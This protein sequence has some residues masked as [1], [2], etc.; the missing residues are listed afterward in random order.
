MK[1]YS[2]IIPG[3]TLPETVKA[4]PLFPSDKGP[5]PLCLLIDISHSPNALELDNDFF[6]TIYLVATID[7]KKTVHELY[8]LHVEDRSRITGF[9]KERFGELSNFVLD[10]KWEKTVKEWFAHSSQELIATGFEE[11]NPSPLLLDINDGGSS[12]TEN[13]SIC[14]DDSLLSAKSFPPYNNSL[15]RILVSKSEDGEQSF[16][17]GLTETSN[18]SLLPPETLVSDSD[19]YSIFNIQ[20]GRYLLKKHHCR[21]YLEHSKNLSTS[22]EEDDSFDSAS[23]ALGSGRLFQTENCRES[24]ILEILHLKLCIFAGAVGQTRREIEKTKEPFFNITDKS[25]SVDVSNH[26]FLPSMWTSDVHLVKPGVAMNY[27]L[28]GSDEVLYLNPNK[29]EISQYWPQSAGGSMQGVGTVLFQEVLS[30]NNNELQLAGTLDSGSAIDCEIQDYVWL[31]LEQTDR[32]QDLFLQIQKEEMDGTKV[33]FRTI[34]QQLSQE[35]KQ[36]ILNSMGIPV[37]NTFWEVLPVQSSA[38]DLYSL[39][40]LGVKTFLESESRNCSRLIDQINEIAKELNGSEISDKKKMAEL[41]QSNSEWNHLF[42][43]GAICVPEMGNEEARQLLP[44]KVWND[45]LYLIIKMFHGH[46]VSFCKHLGDVPPYNLSAP[47]IIAEDKLNE[48]VN[49]LKAILFGNWNM[50]LEVAEVIQ[51][52][53]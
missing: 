46:P 35:N 25:F 42:S 21:E 14:Q 2:Q 29:S 30:D 34:S 9:F 44:E 22:W 51:S 45:I 19:K 24:S 1:K 5:L 53:K 12:E 36:W 20:C 38:Y 33:K 37:E 52:L 32:R 3:K 26:S 11:V 31:R 49:Q 47:L 41:I 23:G 4:C 43:P 48:L 15:T 18:S 16:L 8:D 50:N 10:R 39:G 28:P 6:S 7:Q 17:G 40:V 13:W 27:N